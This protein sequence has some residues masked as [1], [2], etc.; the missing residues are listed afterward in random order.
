MTSERWRK[1]PG[2]KNY[3]AV[4]DQGRVKSL[5]RRVRIVSK[6]GDEG[7]RRKKEH[8]LRLLPQNGGYLMAY[9]SVD[10]RHYARTVHSLVMLS[11][12]GKR[13]RGKD[14]CHNN[15]KRKDNRLS[16]LRYATRKE[17]FQDMHAHG[18]YYRRTGGAKLTEKQ[19]RFIKQRPGVP[20]KT[21]ALKFKVNADTV[22]KI[23]RG[24]TWSHL[25]S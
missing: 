18:T 4:S 13:P 15:G 7:F 6:K 11:F 21:L 14:C 5:A 20:A 17:N 25:T 16:N 19:I 12:R 1:I 24:E 22:C 8:R 23:R 2:F 3:Y 10:G 9:L